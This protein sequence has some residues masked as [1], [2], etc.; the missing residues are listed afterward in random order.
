MLGLIVDKLGDSLEVVVLG[1]GEGLVVRMLKMFFF[2]VGV[3]V[4]LGRI[5]FLGVR[6]FIWGM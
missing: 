1:L 2:F 6:E 5:V 3:V 4:G